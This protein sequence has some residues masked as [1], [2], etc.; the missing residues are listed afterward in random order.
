MRG[1]VLS[2]IFEPTTLN[3]ETSR[4]ETIWSSSTSKDEL[5]MVVRSN[6]PQ[7][8]GSNTVRRILILDVWVKS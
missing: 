8:T 2:A 1:M 7:V 6:N 5:I 4:D 3:A